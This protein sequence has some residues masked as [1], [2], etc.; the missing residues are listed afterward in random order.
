MSVSIGQLKVLPYIDP[1]GNGDTL[2]G[3]RLWIDPS[4]YT[5]EVRDYLPERS[6]PAPEY[7][8]HILTVDLVPELVLDTADLREWLTDGPGQQL[9]ARICNGHDIIWD[10]RNQVGQLDADAEAALEELTKEL[11]E[12]PLGGWEII[13]DVA[14]YLYEWAKSAIT[15]DMTEADLARLATEAERLAAQEKCH[16]AGDVQ[17]YLERVLAEKRADESAADAEE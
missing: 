2:C 14:E 3:L 17:K 7:H 10:G 5:C 16:I 12:W 6:V 13:K 1:N 4:A 9:L 11:H 8:N 15:A